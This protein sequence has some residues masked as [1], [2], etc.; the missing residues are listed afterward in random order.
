MKNL[1]VAAPEKYSGEDDGDVVYIRVGRV[2]SVDSEVEDNSSNISNI[3][4]VSTL[5]QSA[6]SF[7]RLTDIDNK[8]TLY[9]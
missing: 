9:D 7:M 6:D 1:R 8:I 3:S 5:L 2:E 4:E